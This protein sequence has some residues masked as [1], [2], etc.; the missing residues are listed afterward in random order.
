MYAYRK[1]Y[2]SFNFSSIE[3]GH[4]YQYCYEVEGNDVILSEFL[5]P[6]ANE[7]GQIISNVEEKI[8]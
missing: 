4:F 7:H 6:S 8:V 3:L 5:A 2:W 1:N